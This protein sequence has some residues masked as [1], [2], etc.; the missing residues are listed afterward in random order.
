MSSINVNT[1]SAL[2]D[3]NKGAHGAPSGESRYV[4]VGQETAPAI[5][6]PQ[7]GAPAWVKSVR[8]GARRVAR[9][10]L[11]HFLLFGFLLFVASRFYQEQHSVYDIVVTPQHVAQIARTYALQYGTPPD[12]QTLEGLVERDVH[13][14]ILFRQ[15]AAL[16]LDQGDEIVRRRVVQKMQFLVQD[17]NPPA[18]P[19]QAALV[20]YYKAHA[21]RYV[22]APRTTFTHIYFSTDAG[23]D[24]EAR[25]RSVLAA[26]PGSLKRAP[27]RGDAFPDLYDFSAY[28]P[29]QVQRLFGR[30]PLADAVFAAPV[31]RWSGPFRSGYGWHLIFVDARQAAALPPFASVR[32]RVRSDYLQ[33]AQDRAN[34]AAFDDLA[35][36]F[37]V[38]REDRGQ[39]P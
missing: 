27:E 37:T 9:E 20:A 19:S 16:G 38:V 15:G 17:L 22:A 6:R 36:R 26:L 14:E 23:G 21:D 30:T 4:S 7:R 3:G 2:A 10:P 35:R 33:D 39:T 18:E 29:E 31:G 12:A 11:T 8:A 28:E 1:N 34:R 24:A 13:D 32:E 25:A 5:A